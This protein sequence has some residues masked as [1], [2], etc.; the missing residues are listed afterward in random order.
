MEKLGR[1]VDSIT[2]PNNFT[3]IEKI[4]QKWHL[5]RIAMV[6][7]KL[8]PFPKYRVKYFEAED[9]RNEKEIKL[10]EEKE[11]SVTKIYNWRLKIP[12]GTSSFIDELEE[13]GEK[14]YSYVLTRKMGVHEVL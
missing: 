5:P 9:D 6:D 13:L 3:N 4:S 1:L 11:K 2:S 14:L 12:L 8:L 10:S 7:S